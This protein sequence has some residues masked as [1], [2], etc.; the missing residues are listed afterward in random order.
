MKL[1]C[2]PS[3]TW[4]LAITYVCLLLNHLSSAALGWTTPIQEMNGRT[5]DISKILQFSFYEL[6]YYHTYSENFSSLSNEAQGWWVGIAIHV[7]DALT[8]IKYLP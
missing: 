8:Y 3:N 2:A 4:L 5:P 1:S 7:G 6:V